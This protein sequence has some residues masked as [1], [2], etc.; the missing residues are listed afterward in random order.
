MAEDQEAPGREHRVDFNRPDTHMHKR[1]RKRHIH[2][3]T[4]GP[5]SCK[6]EDPAGVS[7]SA[8]HRRLSEVSSPSQAF[9]PSNKLFE[10]LK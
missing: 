8:D 4:H 7:L 9:F 2:A 1:K 3:E 6:T 10:D 5:D